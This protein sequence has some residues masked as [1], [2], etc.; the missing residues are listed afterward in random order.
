VWVAQGAVSQ[1]DS[2]NAVRALSGER[3]VG[4]LMIA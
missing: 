1:E 4:L 3:C 2:L